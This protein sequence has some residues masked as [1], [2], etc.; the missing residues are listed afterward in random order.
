ML[1]TDGY[2]KGLT[3]SGDAK[4]TEQRLARNL[5]EKQ[6]RRCKRDKGYVLGTDAFHVSG[7]GARQRYDASRIFGVAA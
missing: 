5:Q 3:T 2:A 6:L 4:R 1:R 7:T